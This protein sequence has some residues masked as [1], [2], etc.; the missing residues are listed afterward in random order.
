MG[1]LCPGFGRSKFRGLQQGMLDSART[2]RYTHAVLL[3]VFSQAVKW[4]ML[5]YNPASDVD[6]PKQH[7]KE[8]RVLAPDQTRQFLD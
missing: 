1:A 7:R 6:L 5:A 4:R 2:V 3:S 8:M